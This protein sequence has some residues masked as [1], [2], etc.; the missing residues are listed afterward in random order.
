MATGIDKNG[1]TVKVN[2]HVSIIGK[3]VSVSGS[4][5]LAVV[6]VQAPLDAGTFNAVANDC[7]AVEHTSDASH[8]AVSVD[9]KPYG[10]VGNDLTARGVVTAISGSGLNAVMTVKLSASGTSINTATG[11]AT[12]VADVS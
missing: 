8:P 7:G 12:S 6:T 1:V 5:S 9:G 10:L 3:V 4:G 2:A 11:N